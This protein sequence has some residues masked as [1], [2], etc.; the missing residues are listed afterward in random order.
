VNNTYQELIEKIRGASLFALPQSVV[1]FLELT[2]DPANGPPEY[3]VPI[4]IDPG[5]TSQILRFANSS[6]FGF[7]HKISTVQMAMTLV[8]VRTIK[9]FMLWN[10]VF[11]L[12]P[13]PKCGPFS[14]KI[15]VLDSLRRS[16]FT[17]A[18]CAYFPEL[19]SEELFVA[20]LLQDLTIPILAQIWPKEYEKI[21]TQHR[22]S[23][24][25]IS[26]LEENTF[27][28][29]HMDAGAFL[30]REWG[31]GDDLASKIAVHHSVGDQNRDGKKTFLEKMIIKLSSLAPSC[32]EKEW[33]DTDDFFA[34]FSKIQIKGLTDIDVF[35]QAD[36]LFDDLLKVM[37]FENP[38]T[39]ITS[40][41]RQYLSSMSY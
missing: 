5:L 17:K 24:T 33:K 31:F 39:G 26:I 16:S 14:L 2:K 38:E 7:R 36:Q 30:V 21:L 22:E 8:S 29:N 15:F 34:I 12:L 41:H 11:A 37:Q 32:L 40:F 3:A 27:G 1:R 19:D 10:A 28:W 9:N 23:G 20:A 13:D 18:L 25:C 4:S 6:F 35:K